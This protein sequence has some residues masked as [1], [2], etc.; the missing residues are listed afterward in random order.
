MP[1]RRKTHSGK[2]FLRSVLDS[3]ADGFYGVDRDDVT[4]TCHAAFLRMLDF[5][6]AEDAV[7]KKLHGVIHHSHADEAAKSFNFRRSLTRRPA[8]FPP[9]QQEFVL[10]AEANKM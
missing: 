10:T 2:A 3:A 5:E 9:N 7:G 6:R 4:T 1:D 8:T